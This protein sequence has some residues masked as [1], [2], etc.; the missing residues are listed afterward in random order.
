LSEAQ[1]YL[2]KNPEIVWKDDTKTQIDP[3]WF[4]H[5]S[6]CSLHLEI[7]RKKAMDYEIQVWRVGDAAMVAV[8][9]EP[10]VEGQLDIKLNSPA[11]FTFVM[12]MTSHYVGYVPTYDAFKRVGHETRLSTWSKLVPEALDL[13]VQDTGKLLKTVF[14]S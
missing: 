4:K 10:F 11:K 14:Q 3:E 1:K 9:G 6:L 5:A 12:H 13:I 8:P 7:K 2:E